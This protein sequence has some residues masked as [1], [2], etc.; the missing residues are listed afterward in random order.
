[1]RK[2]SLKKLIFVLHFPPYTA[3]GLRPHYFSDIWGPS[4]I[5]SFRLGLPSTPISHENGA[6]QNGP[7]RV[8]GWKATGVLAHYDPGHN[9]LKHFTPVPL[10]VHHPQD[11]LETPTDRTIERIIGSICKLLYYEFDYYLQLP[12]HL[13]VVLTSSL[14]I[15][16]DASR[17][18]LSAI[19]MMTA[20]TVQTNMQIAHNRLAAP[21]SLPA[22]TN[23][24]FL[25]SGHVT[26]IMTVVI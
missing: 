11:W 12:L 24:V 17:N 4:F 3:L 9:S 10:C 1:M 8:N 21:P 14:A 20:V 19:L 13:V 7:F 15:T 18:D 6:F 23:A 22:T 26:A 16:H 5:S 2:N 25:Q